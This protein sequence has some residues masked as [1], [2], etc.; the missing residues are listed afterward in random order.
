VLEFSPL[1]LNRL[2]LDG[3]FGEII[4][5]VDSVH[6]DI[7]GED[8]VSNT[9]F[10]VNEINDF[11]CDIPKHVHIMSFNPMQYIEKLSCVDSISFHY[12][13][14]NIL[15]TIKSIKNKNIKVGLV[16]NPQTDIEDVFEFVPLLDRVIIM[17]VNPGFSG[18][19]Y[20]SDTS[21]R[22]IKLRKY[23]NDIE[24]VIDGGMNEHTI[25][26]VKTLGADAYIIC[27]VKAKSDDIESKI[28]ELKKSSDSGVLNKLLL[29]KEDS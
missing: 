24:I 11:K 16:I 14:G 18:Q 5:H 6:L 17:A 10:T 25:R 20:I 9:A 7:M 23:S 29:E 21:S 12:E 2:H 13:V 1:C 19:K 28:K 15:N 8:F 3:L 26:E 22:I 27:S 4:K